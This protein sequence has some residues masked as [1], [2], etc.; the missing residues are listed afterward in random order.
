MWNEEAKTF[1]DQLRTIAERRNFLSKLENR[2][3]LMIC[4]EYIKQLEN[5]IKGLER[6][7]ERNDNPKTNPGNW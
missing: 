5:E 3:T 6:E 1:C 4:E 2:T 7:L